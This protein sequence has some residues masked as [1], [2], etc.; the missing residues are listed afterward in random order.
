MPNCKA[1][2]G[3]KWIYTITTETYCDSF[4]GD[5]ATYTGVKCCMKDKCNAPDRKLDPITK[6]L[7]TAKGLDRR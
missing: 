3:E 6:I 2:D 1:G 7:P 5:T 4:K